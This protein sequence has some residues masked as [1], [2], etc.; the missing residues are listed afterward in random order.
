MIP[1]AITFTIPGKP[2]AK[3]RHRAAFNRHLGRVMTYD[4]AGNISFERQVGTIAAPFFPFP[5]T[6][7][8]LLSLVAVFQ[9]ATSL[10]KAKRAALLGT[11]HTQKP[12][13]DNLLKSVK[14]GLNRIAWADDAQVADGICVKVWGEVAETRVIIEPL[15]AVPPYP[16]RQ[17]GSVVAPSFASLIEAAE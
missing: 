8:V 14:D 6:G 3:R 13:R 17:I 11:Y 5:L 9:P 16:W 4:D 12:D 7:P 15:P 2:F 10:S 1:G